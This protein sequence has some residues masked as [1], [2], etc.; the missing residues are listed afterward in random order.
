MRPDHRERRHQHRNG[1]ENGRRPAEERLQSQPEI[2]PDA[3]VR[4]CDRQQYELHRDHMRSQNPIGVQRRC[5][6]GR[7]KSEQCAVEPHGAEMTGEP[8]RN[9]QAEHELR[10]LNCRVAK[11]APLIERPQAERE[12]HDGGS[13]ERVIDDRNSPPPDVEP[14]P[15]FHRL[16]GN[17]AERV[18]EEMRKDVGEHDEAGSKPHL[19][20][21]NAAQQYRGLGSRSTRG[22]RTS[23]IRG[24]LCRHGE[25]SFEWRQIAARRKSSAIVT[26]VRNA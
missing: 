22:A 8:E 15:R 23:T 21:A 9:A 19:P 17:V 26:L 11:M 10:D 14:Q 20:H 5:V 2:K 1:E 16:V 25:P 18:I 3:G 13:V 7:G 6:I 12:M 4:P 24:S